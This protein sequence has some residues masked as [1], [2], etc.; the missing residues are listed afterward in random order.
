MQRKKQTK[1][2]FSGRNIKNTSDACQ[3]FENYNTKKGQTK[4]TSFK[5]KKVFPVNQ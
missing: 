4:I 3:S 1:T 2:K 5:G